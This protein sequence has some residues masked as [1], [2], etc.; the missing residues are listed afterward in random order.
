M[1]PNRRTRRYQSMHK[2]K[3]RAKSKQSATDRRQNAAISKL[4]TQQ[5]RLSQYSFQGEGDGTYQSY[6][7]VQPTLWQPIFQSNFRANNTDRAFIQNMHILCNV[8]VSISGTVSYNPLHYV[9]FI[10]SLK[11]EARLQTIQRL[12]PLLTNPQEDIDYSYSPIGATVGNA[13]WRLNP[14]IYNIHAMR[15]GM[16]GNVSQ[17]ALAADAPLVTNIADANRNHKFDVSWKR[18]LKR[19]N[20]VDV[21]GNPLEWKDMT[22]NEVNPADQ[23]Y[24]LM[25]NNASVDQEVAFAWSC[26]ANTKVPQ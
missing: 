10:V 5:Y 16:V 2:P 23:L 13:Q 3:G 17:E 4:L 6:P 24:M 11:K 25:F 20:G 9:I 18:R 21:N 7:L 14:A 1:P 22:V 15:R 19:V 12:S 26:Q 8:T